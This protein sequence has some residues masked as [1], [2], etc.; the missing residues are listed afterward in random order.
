MS[1]CF[2]KLDMYER[3]RESYTFLLEDLALITPDRMTPV[4]EQL[5]ASAEWRLKV[6]TWKEDTESDAAS[7]LNESVES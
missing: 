5:K 7:L 6:L 1:L 2:E 3:A 4:L